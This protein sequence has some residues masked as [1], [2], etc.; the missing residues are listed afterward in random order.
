MSGFYLWELER[1]L[2]IDDTW[3]C[4]WLEPMQL[5]NQSA[6]AFSCVIRSGRKKN[7]EYRADEG[8]QC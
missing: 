7:L 5:P 2:R 8:G 4:G 6:L 3:K 1:I